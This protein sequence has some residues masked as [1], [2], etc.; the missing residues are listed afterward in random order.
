MF[1]EEKLRE[2]FVRRVT[3]GH[4]AWLAFSGDTEAAELLASKEESAA[5]TFYAYWLHVGQSFA[6]RQ[7]GH[8]T[9][10][11]ASARKLEEACPQVRNISPDGC[12]SD[13]RALRAAAQLMPANSPQASLR[14]VKRSGH[15]TSSL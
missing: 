13:A 14:R 1:P 11:I 10:A 7:N 15:R 8:Y 9:A 5:D 6:Q 2:R 12:I 4:V 3:P